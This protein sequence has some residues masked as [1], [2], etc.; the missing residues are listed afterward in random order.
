MVVLFASTA[1][2]FSLYRC[3]HDQIARARCCCPPSQADDSATPTLTRAVCCDVQTVQVTRAPSTTSDS[4]G[5]PA[6]LHAALASFVVL[7]LPRVAA[8]PRAPLTR[9]AIGP[10]ILLLKQSLLI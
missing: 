7:P 1:S 8:M 4:Q 10:P 9:A 6:L 3:R 2:A 5:Q